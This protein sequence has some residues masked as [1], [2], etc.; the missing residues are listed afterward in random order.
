MI[1]QKISSLPR[2][3]ALA[4]SDM[5]PLVDSQFGPA[6]YV[7]KKTTVG[8]LMALAEIIVNNQVSA[9]NTVASVNGFGGIVV[10]SIDQLD[11][12]RVIVPQENQVLAYDS[13]QS[14][15]VNKNL[16]D[17]DLVLDCGNF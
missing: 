10:L 11:N 7:N 4:T 8:D 3:Y 2:K 17:L 14:D 5:L 16:T 6:N 1:D 12:V 13:A 9:L 15:W